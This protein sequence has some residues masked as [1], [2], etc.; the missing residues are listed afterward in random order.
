[1]KYYI[2]ISVLLSW[3]Q[4]SWA[5][6]QFNTSALTAPSYAA[7]SLVFK[8]GF[9]SKDT[10]VVEGY[11]P[12]KNP[13]KATLYSLVPGGG[14]I[15]NG[16]YWKVPIIYAALGTSIYFAI[17]NRQEY[18]YLREQYDFMVDGD[19]ETVSDYEGVTTPQGLANERDKFRGWMELSYV[20]IGA[21]YVLQ[22][23]EANVD[24]HLMDFNVSEDLSMHWSP[25]VVGSVSSPGLGVG[26]ALKLK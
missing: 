11:I 23:I 3:V 18:L 5:Q 14:Q 19:D 22:I 12:S 17:T 9:T 13:K 24:A 20:A 4:V 25:Q 7:Q 6:F 26:L 1:M 21:V 8:K 16:R 2:T 15:Y 10:L